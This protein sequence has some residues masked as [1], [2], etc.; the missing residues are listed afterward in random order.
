M[1][2]LLV[3]VLC[4]ASVPGTKAQ[5]QSSSNPLPLQ[6]PD[7][8][9]GNSAR[10]DV[11]RNKSQAAGQS[12]VTIVVARLGTGEQSRELNRRRLYTIGSYLIAMGLPPQRLVTTE[13]ESVRG[14][15]R[16]E[17]YVGGELVEVLSVKQ[18][19][20]LPVGI[21][22]NDLEDRRRYQLPRRAKASQCH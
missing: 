12:K 2:L 18:C 1:K 3:L 16:I 20:D 21:C 5:N 17:I 11:V 4:L 6:H 8:C 7:N 13:G 15:G 22:D 9:E 10:L 14:F 19:K